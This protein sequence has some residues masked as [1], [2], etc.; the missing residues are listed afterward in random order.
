MRA[1]VIKTYS[2]KKGSPRLERAPL[3]DLAMEV[4]EGIFAQ[5]GYEAHQLRVQ[6]ISRDPLVTDLDLAE[7]QPTEGDIFSFSC[8]AGNMADSATVA[9]YLGRKFPETIVIMGGPNLDRFTC[10]E[11]LGNHPHIDCGLVGLAEF[12]LPHYLR[13]LRERDQDFSKISGLNYFRDG[14]LIST[15]TEYPHSGK[16]RSG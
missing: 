16:E 15:R 3:G 4:V 2:P 12:N 5:N 10:E 6:V 1:F 11:I 9:N 8:V 7:L 13:A 14:E